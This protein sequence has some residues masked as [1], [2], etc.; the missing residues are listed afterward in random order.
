MFRFVQLPELKFDMR[1]D[2]TD[3]G[4]VYTTPNGDLYPSVT[5]VLSNGDNKALEEWKE[6][7][8]LEEANRVSSMAARRGTALHTVC[9]K[10]L[11]NEMSSMKL[12]SLMPTTKEL[13]FKIRPYL[14]ISVG[15]VLAL[16][17]AM[18]SD[19][20]GIAGRVDCIA[21]WNGKLSVVD[22]KSS[23]NQKEKENISNYFMQCTAYS[24]MFRELTK[25][26]ID[27][28]V[29]LIG[30]E[31]GPGQCF[32]E[33]ASNYVAQLQQTVSDFYQKSTLLLN[34]NTL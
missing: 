16:E 18:Y 23:T 10:Y 3:R 32:V 9:E 17:Q 21:E 29:V 19:K 34:K 25:I 26:P 24:I 14:D 8:G 31:N 27:Q 12:A 2:T 6:R 20:L 28:I 22:F 1:A 5:T 15:R 11:L 33:S 4:R 7:V 30:T 13:F